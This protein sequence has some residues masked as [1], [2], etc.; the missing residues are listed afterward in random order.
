MLVHD[1]IIDGTRHKYGVFNT[2]VTKALDFVDEQIGQLAGALES[3]GVLE[4]TN[5]VLLSDHGQRDFVRIL[6]PNVF[7]A[8]RGLLRV[9]ASGRVLDWKA[10][11]ISNAMS[12]MVYL[13]DPEDPALF[14]EVGR[15]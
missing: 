7:L 5:L 2:E 6:K 13:K 10:Y 4:E 3:A 12:S 11:S 8:D 1:G 15:I 14:R 9:D